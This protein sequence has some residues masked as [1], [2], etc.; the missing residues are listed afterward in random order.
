MSGTE[1]NAS[2]TVGLVLSAARQNPVSVTQYGAVVTSQGDALYCATSGALPNGFIWTIL[3][4]GTLQS[5]GGDGI[6]TGGN[7][8]LGNTGDIAGSAYG[9]AAAGS[10]TIVNGPGTDGTA[11][12]SSV[13]DAVLVFGNDSYIYNGG[14]LLSSHGIGAELGDAANSTIVNGSSS[15]TGALI[16]GAVTGIILDTGAVVNYGTIE[17]NPTG[18][19]SDY[20]VVLGGGGASSTIL[21]YGIIE[22]GSGVLATPSD[23]VLNAGTIIGGGPNDMA[24]LFAGQPDQQADLIVDPGAVFEGA[25]KGG[26]VTIALELASGSHAGTLDMGGSF[27]GLGSIAFGPGAAWTLEGT[28][29][30]LAAGQTIA[31]FDTSDT[32]VLDGFAA[33]SASYMTGTGL[34]LASPTGSSVL[35]ITGSF[36]TPDFSVTSS[37]N[38]TTITL[39]T[40]PCFCAGTRIRT[41]LG[42][43]P[44][45]DLRIGDEVVTAF[46]GVQRIKWIGRRAYDGRFIAGNHLALPVCLRAGA[47]ADDVP[48]RD[49][50]V[51]PDHAICEG[52]VLIHAWRLLN[53]VSI[54][55][56]ETVE[57]VQYF[58]I[59]FDAH[60]VIFAENCPAESFA[61]A[62]CRARFHNADEF[63]QFYGDAGDM[64]QCLPRLQGGFH[65]HSIQRRLAARAGVVAASA[66][67]GPL[68]GNLDEV[69]PTRLHGWA[70]DAS[71]PDEPVVLDIS[72]DGARLG[73]VLANEYRPDLRA[74]GLGS[75]CHAFTLPLP[76]G[77]RGGLDIRRASDGTVLCLPE[78][79][80]VA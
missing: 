57:A 79:L 54:I 10:G 6:Y 33:T 53:G 34:V 59:E 27:L 43:V 68:H 40:A 36:S 51:S 41:P 31:G 7:L 78:A 60:Q 19:A 2:Y 49:L 38:Q 48:A 46:A 74:A 18:G 67:P 22:S 47:I 11:V 75:G 13:R 73:H 35:E 65:L 20:G 23:T 14:T 63:V 4:D 24:I 17:G 62:E 29:A 70:Q 45:E 8:S 44:V 66:P 55:Q 56:A 61:D 72:C 3:N 5:T 21:N 37:G 64:A 32:I 12:I 77:W 1:I 9:V 71:R 50:W 76:Q 16:Y 42:E 15:H 39:E 80:R 58:H 30:E 28:A 25:V 69:G 52:G 26:N